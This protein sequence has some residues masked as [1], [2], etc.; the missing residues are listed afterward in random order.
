MGRPKGSKNQTN[1]KRVKDPNRPKRPTSAYF[2]FAA[3]CREDN[4]KKGVKIT[5]VA[6]FTK[7]VSAK[8]NGLGAKEKEPYEKLAAKDKQRYDAEVAKYKG[9]KVKDSNKPKRPQT[10]Y[11]LFLADFREKM[12]GKIKVHKEIL[13]AAGEAWK[14][15]SDTERKPYDQRAE[16]EREKYE[17]KM[18]EYRKTGGA[19][20][21]AAKKAKAEAANGTD[22]EDDIDDEEED[23]DEEEEDEEDDE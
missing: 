18:A 4:A 20:E 13:V 12:K 22:E 21:P 16:K 17:V 15:L 2:Y 14:G 9:T 7:E 23:E 19:G 11:F 8:W 3:K 5:R 1:R 6:D 10:A